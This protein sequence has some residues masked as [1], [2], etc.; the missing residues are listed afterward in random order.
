MG[1][2]ISSKLDRSRNRRQLDWFIVRWFDQ[3]L[4][5]TKSIPWWCSGRERGNLFK[6]RVKRNVSKP[7]ALNYLILN[8][9]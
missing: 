1:S 9:R 8:S 3:R 7:N 4:V 6:M 2:E 5:D